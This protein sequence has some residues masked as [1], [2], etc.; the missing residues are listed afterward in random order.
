MHIVT[1]QKALKLF[2]RKKLRTTMTCP[3]NS[4]DL[5]P[6]E[7]L[8]WKLKK[9]SLMRKRQSPKKIY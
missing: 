9:R 7:N 5:N 4:P 1:E 8:W 3:A 2:F 6:L